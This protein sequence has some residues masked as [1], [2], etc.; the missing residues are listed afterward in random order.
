MA[1]DQY[2]C[3]CDIITLAFTHLLIVSALLM[4]MHQKSH[5]LLL[6]IVCHDIAYKCHN[7]I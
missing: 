5:C 7:V 3:Y 4:I 6:Y 1:M 2:Y